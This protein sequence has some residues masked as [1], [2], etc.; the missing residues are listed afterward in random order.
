MSSWVQIGSGCAHGLATAKE[1]FNNISW[2]EYEKGVV[3]VFLG[4]P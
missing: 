4:D 3:Y 1:R 2:R